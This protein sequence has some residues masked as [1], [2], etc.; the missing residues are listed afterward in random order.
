MLHRICNLIIH[1]PSCL[2]LHASTR[3]ISYVRFDWSFIFRVRIAKNV[4]L[5]VVWSRWW[6]KG[7]EISKI[8]L[9]SFNWV[10]ILWRMRSK[11]QYKIFWKSVAWKFDILDSSLVIFFRVFEGFKKNRNKPLCFDLVRYRMSLDVSWSPDKK[12]N[13][14][15]RLK[16]TDNFD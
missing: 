15:K 4:D 1:P 8:Y 5:Q 11:H 9:L 14:Y 10:P 13:V 6:Q 3:S 12:K 16:N 7:I 2:C